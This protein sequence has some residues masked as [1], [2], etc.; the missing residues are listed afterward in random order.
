MS[1]QN[2]SSSIISSQWKYDVFL[3]S[4]NQ[5][6][7]K[8]FTNHLHTALTRK[9]INVFRN[10]NELK[11]GKSIESE[12]FKAIE[13]SRF[14]IIVFSKTYAFS[15]LCLEE[16]VKIVE[17][18]HTSDERMIFPIF[19][20][21]KPT[22]VSKQTGD[23]KEAFVKYEQAFGQVVEKVQKWKNSLKEVANIS[24][25]ELEERN[26]LKLI[27]HIVK[28]IS[29]K[30]IPKKLKIYKKLV[31]INSRLDKLTPLLDK[32]SYNVRMIGIWGMSGVGKT[33][34]ARIIYDLISWQFEG[35]S[36]LAISKNNN[37]VSL[38]NNLL[39]NLNIKRANN[40]IH[41]VYEGIKMIGS[42]LRHKKILI[43]IDNVVELKQLESLA[44]NCDW[45]GSGSRIIITSS[46]AHLMKT[47]G[48]DDD[49]L[50]E[51]ERVNG[52][53]ARKLFCMEAFKPDDPKENFEHL[54]ER[55]V[56]YAAGLPLVLRVFGSSLHGETVEKWKSALQRL[57][58]DYIP[59]KIYKKLQISFHGLEKRYQK[60]FLDIACLYKTK[61]KDYVVKI[62]ESCDF[63]PIIG[64]SVLREK[65][66]VFVTHDNKLWMHD[67][68]QE[69]GQQTVKSESEES[70][71][72]SRLWEEEDIRHVLSKNLGTEA[73]EAISLS[74][75]TQAIEN[76][77]DD[78][79]P[80]THL[81]NM[82][83]SAE[84]FL[85]MINLRLLKICY[86]K[87][88]EGLEYL[89]NELRFLEW[90]GYPFEVLATEISSI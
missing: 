54:T 30:L 38:Q 57:E 25:W 21:V 42:R 14:S 72:R 28:E 56:Q 69:M 68:L 78:C 73:V 29:S 63:N 50:Y 59:E 24:G 79:L 87:F 31:G 77:G 32:R 13:E 58:R 20:D 71:E 3:S 22:M 88:P 52:D 66:L 26:E 53:E 84:V 15:T 12:P 2:V 33:T 36:F 82:D 47:H 19:Y 65:S 5:G 76:I 35:S 60:I 83:L 48:V 74:V 44:G 34:I 4:S 89:P 81:A 7:C 17:Y 61:D 80:D 62:L 55:F 85:K 1:I 46:D 18:K 49:Q 37:L 23:F 8:N 90:T 40:S 43:V 86:M 27:E 9:W 10:N 16:L 64:L 41:N 11:R 75:N 67:L 6:T 51:L 45:F 70:G 39:D